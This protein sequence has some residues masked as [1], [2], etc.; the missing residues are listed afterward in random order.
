MTGASD[1]R[2]RRLATLLAALA[3]AAV[4]AAVMIFS[5]VAGAAGPGPAPSR[6]TVPTVAGKPVSRPLA[7]A[8]NAGDPSTIGAPG[9]E[10]SDG[11]PPR[12][13][14][15]R[16]FSPAAAFANGRQRSRPQPCSRP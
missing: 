13:P 9:T 5:A 14:K 8:A 12:P 1:A 6:V 11:M 7:A 2:P 15:W 16:Q 3:A 4:V 10:G